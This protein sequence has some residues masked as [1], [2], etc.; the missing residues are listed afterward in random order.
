[1]GRRLL[2]VGLLL[3]LAALAACQGEEARLAAHMSRADAYLE[4]EKPA[5]AIIE[6]RNAL[7]LNPNLA[8]AHWGLSRAYL[9]TG[10]AGKAYWEV[11]EAVRLDPGNAEARL[12][13]G[14]FLLFGKSDELERAVEQADAVLAGDADRADAHLLRG[15]ALERLQRL[16]EAEAAYQRSAQLDPDGPERLHALAGFYVRRG[17]REQAEPVLRDLAQRDPSFRSLAALATFVGQD[18]ERVVEA[19]RLYRTAIEKATEAERPVAYQLLASYYYGRERYPDAEQALRE[20]LE[21]TEDPL[22]LIYALARLY[23]ARGDVA[24][25]DAMIEEATRARPTEVRPFLVLSAYRGRTGD[26]AGA[27]EAAEAALAVD[28]ESKPARLRKAELLVDLGLREDSKEHLARGR[29]IVD[30]VLAAEPASPEALFVKA[31]LHIAQQDLDAA[32]AALRRALDGRPDWAQAHLLL[33]STL[34]LRGDRQGARA[35][36]LRALELDAQLLEARLLLARAYASLGEH[37]LA[38]EE[39]RRVL[40]DRPDDQTM[41]ILLAQSLVHLRKPSEALQ[42]LEAIP[43]AER[44]AEVH[45]AL[46]RI[47]LLDGRLDASRRDLLRAAEARPHHP[48]ILESLLEVER[49]TDQVEASLQRIAA[50]VKAEPSNSR[51]TR[52]E[53]V[54]LLVAG[55]RSLA[56]QKLRAAVELDPNDLTSQQTLAQ[57]LM[58]TGRLEESLRTYEQ[59]IKARP[60][61]A[62]LHLIVGS[63]YELSGRHEPAV[64]HYE[65]AVRIDPDLAVAKNNLAYLLAEQGR[66]LD[67]ALDLAQ[68]AKE[69]LPD[70]PNVADT[71]GWVLLKKGIPQAAI[72]YLKEAEGGFPPGR[73]ELGIVRHHLAQAYAANG[74]PERA[75]EALDRALADLD[76]PR[77]GAESGS[78][79]PAE[80]DWAADARALRERLRA[81]AGG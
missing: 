12:A 42:Q 60:D 78:A 17:Q 24:K 61:S 16:D 6:Y 34:M 3:G 28:A 73:G 70:S 51:L 26:L 53:G 64:E 57:Y 30:S 18:A 58:A 8:N 23:H 81:S 74:E 11:Q 55:Q 66:S 68:E 25:A 50:A 15:R 79:P 72:G 75:L 48:D 22:D 62:P 59:A 41:R 46:G 56:E 35:E 44:D 52:L 33:G 38:A 71:L 63:L 40:E 29:A 69:L 54:A 32:A 37:D 31:K 13:L 45:F 7:Q 39:A 49:R 77:P 4:E 10:E 1:M 67:R 2:P 14:G 43:A 20:G 5:E 65:Q 47:H 19:E 36:A 9:A 76:A 80:P 27:L 21:H